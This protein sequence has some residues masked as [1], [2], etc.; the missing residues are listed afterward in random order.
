MLIKNILIKKY[1]NRERMRTKKKRIR[2]VWAR[3]E[4]L[5]LY[6]ILG[7]ETQAHS[8]RFFFKG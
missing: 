5:T 6:E 7:M 2:H 3:Y 4:H 1:E 8:T